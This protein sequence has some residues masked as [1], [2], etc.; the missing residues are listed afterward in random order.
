MRKINLEENAPTFDLLIPTDRRFLKNLAVVIG[1]WIL[2]AKECVLKG[3]VNRVRRWQVLTPAGLQAMNLPLTASDQLACLHMLAGV[4]DRL[5]L[6]RLEKLGMIA[7]NE[8]FPVLTPRGKSTVDALRVAD[9]T[10]NKDFGRSVIEEGER[11]GA[12]AW[13]S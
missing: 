13:R 10:K 9:E 4:P 5:C 11:Y 3:W 1:P 7:C 2:A 8:G 12:R 6:E